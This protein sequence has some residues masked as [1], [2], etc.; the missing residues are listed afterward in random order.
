M[1]I[2][3]SVHEFSP[4]W[5]LGSLNEMSVRHTWDTLDVDLLNC[6]FQAHLEKESNPM[7]MLWFLL[8]FTGS[9]APLNILNTDGIRGMATR[10]KSPFSR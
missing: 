5:V 1:L 3:V 8:M 6:P 9:S 4:L 2:V 10:L 7:A